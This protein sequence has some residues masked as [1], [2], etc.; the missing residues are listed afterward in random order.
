MSP[1]ARISVP[2]LAFIS[3]TT[4]RCILRACQRAVALGCGACR[5]VRLGDRHTPALELVLKFEG[6]GL[7]LGE[8]EGLGL[9]LDILDGDVN[10]SGGIGYLGTVSGIYGQAVDV[11]ITARIGSLG[12]TAPIAAGYLEL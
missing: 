10:F 1:A 8:L 5:A 11:D 3:T 2:V 9:R 4:F 7:A 6:S 12:G